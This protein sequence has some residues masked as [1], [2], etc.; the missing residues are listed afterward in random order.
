VV[1]PAFAV[2]LPFPRRSLVG[3][4]SLTGLW[5]SDKFAICLF[6]LGANTLN[7]VIAAEGL[8]E[9]IGGEVGRVHL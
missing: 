4:D 5:S 7:E 8:V 1:L 3:S 9:R 6:T 2:I